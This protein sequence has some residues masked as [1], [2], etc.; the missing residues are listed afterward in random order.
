MNTAHHLC[1]NKLIL[2]EGHQIQ[3]IISGK[4]SLNISQ[5]QKAS[6][7]QVNVGAKTH[8]TFCLLK[9]GKVTSEMKGVLGGFRNGEFTS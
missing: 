1:G 7:K 2:Q 3:F 5:Y 9:G 8:A 4:I 6:A